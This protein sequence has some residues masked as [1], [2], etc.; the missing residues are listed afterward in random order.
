MQPIDTSDSCAPDCSDNVL[1]NEEGEI[2]AELFPEH[3]GDK[4]LAD[5]VLEDQVYLDLF[6]FHVFEELNKKL[7]TCSGSN[8]LEDIN[9]KG[10]G[11]RWV[12][13]S[14]FPTLVRSIGSL[15][16]PPLWGRRSEGRSRAQGVGGKGGIGN[17][18][19]SFVVIVV[20]LL[21]GAGRY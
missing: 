4:I 14:T 12:T 8:T 16:K 1:E 18:G 7:V 3:Q 13:F 5:F 6:D 11:P 9:H 17:F 19:I 2:L 15:E 20:L 21:Y 10:L